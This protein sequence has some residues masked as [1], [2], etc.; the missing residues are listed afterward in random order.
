M[1]HRQTE[2]I[3]PMMPTSTPTQP[4]Q[5][6]PAMA[7]GPGPMPSSQ[8]PLPSSVVCTI[9]TCATHSDVLSLVFAC[10]CS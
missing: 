1:L 6:V 8:V 3:P 5:Q 7:S 10:A 4:Q 2:Q 9:R